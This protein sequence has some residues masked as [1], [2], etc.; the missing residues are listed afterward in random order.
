M[1]RFLSVI[2]F[3]ALTLT[4]SAPQTADTIYYNGHLVTMWD[5][6]PS[7]EAVAIRGN[8]FLA[9]WMTFSPTGAQAWFTGVGTYSGNIATLVNVDQP[10]IARAKG[11]PSP[12]T[13]SQRCHARRSAM[14]FRTPPR[15][16]SPTTEPE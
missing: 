2:F 1:M 10:V 15:D 16:A 9:V 6:H 5:A 12:S 14:N 4:Q 8:R 3:L 13:A 11:R 7:V